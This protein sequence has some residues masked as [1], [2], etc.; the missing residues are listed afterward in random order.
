[1]TYLVVLA[2]VGLTV[3]FGW[4]S[5]T[6]RKALAVSQAETEQVRVEAARV[7]SDA[8]R[9]KARYEPLTN[10]ESE[11]ARLNVQVAL[12]Q[13]EIE[14]LAE[15]YVGKKSIYDRLVAESAVYDGRAAFA[16]LGVYEPHFNYDDSETYKVAIMTV[17]QEQKDTVAAKNAVFCTTD[18]RVDGSLAKGKTMTNRGIKL[19]LR[20]FNNECEAA[21]ANVRWSNAVAMEKRV[22]RAFEKISALNESSAIRINPVFLELKLKELRLTHEYREKLKAEREERA[23]LARLAREEARLQRDLERAEED[24]ARYARLLEQA[25]QEVGSVSG[26]KLEAFEK[27]V[28]MLEQDLAAAHAKTERAR[29]MAEQTRSGFVY[30]I[31]NIGSFGEGVVKIGLTRRLDPLDR[32][33]ELGDASVPFLFD[34]HAIIYSDDAPALERALH[35]EFEST[36]INGQNMRKEF[37]RAP[38]DEVEQAVGRLAPDASFFRDVEAQEFR[39]TMAKRQAKLA[40]EAARESV[41]PNSI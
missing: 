5:R 13:T 24:E 37:F 30:I 40:E 23:E 27:Q 14:C 15:S 31:S 38:I 20:A 11:I 6:I 16:E 34:T 41:F 29:A 1:V 32:V 26:A 12:K 7:Q 17:R 33:R 36:R 18:W 28:A 2:L 21:I 10:I 8:D 35:V 22:V 4:Q 25:R 9:L 3:W 39:E 19:T